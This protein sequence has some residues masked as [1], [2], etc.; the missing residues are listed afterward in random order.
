MTRFINLKRGAIYLIKGCGLQVG[1]SDR[2]G[3]TASILL[4]RGKG[5]RIYAE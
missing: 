3:S 2:L 4:G 5:N 1:H